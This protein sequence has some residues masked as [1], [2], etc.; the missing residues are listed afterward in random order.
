MNRLND[1]WNFWQINKMK[2]THKVSCLS[3][4]VMA[5]S[6]KLFQCIQNYY[7]TMGIMNSYQSQQIFSFNW[8]NLSFF[9]AMILMFISTFSFF[10]FN[11]S[12]VADYGS[13]FFGSVSYLNTIVDF[14]TNIWQIPNILL[15]IAVFEKYIEMSK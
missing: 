14:I 5:G 11:A 9:C 4:S 8:K 1:F 12:T 6:V 10:L 3:I 13:S 2:S 15:L 7:Q